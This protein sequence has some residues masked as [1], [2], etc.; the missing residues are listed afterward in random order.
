MVILASKGMAFSAF[1]KNM[2]CL[3]GTICMGS[4]L[5]FASI[6]LAFPYDM[7]LNTK[8][9]TQTKFYVWL[10]HLEVVELPID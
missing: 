2:Q 4:T 5:I 8:L 3:Q 9:V 1:L 6:F 7:F 10:G